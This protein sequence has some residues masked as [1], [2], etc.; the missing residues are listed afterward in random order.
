MKAADGG[1]HLLYDQLDGGLLLSLCIESILIMNKISIN[2]T[3]QTCKY[4]KSNQDKRNTNSQFLRWAVVI[5]GYV[6]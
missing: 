5:Y 1:N 2:Q 6:K 3:F 4:G